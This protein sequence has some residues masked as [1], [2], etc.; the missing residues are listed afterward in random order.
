MVW[1]HD[2]FGVIWSQSIWI[3]LDRE[4]IYKTSPKGVGAQ[5][6][7]WAQP[8]QLQKHIQGFPTGKTLASLSPNLCQSFQIR[9]MG[10]VAFINQR[11]WSLDSALAQ[12]VGLLDRL[13]EQAWTLTRNQ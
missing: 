6:T 8:G 10:G 11:R 7:G 12:I 9:K 2:E 3:I 5:H 13:V 1:Y 4:K